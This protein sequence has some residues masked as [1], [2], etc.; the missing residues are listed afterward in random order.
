[1]LFISLTRQTIKH[2]RSYNL[3]HYCPVKLQCI[4]IL[5][6]WQ[7]TLI[8]QADGLGAEN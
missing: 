6:Q 2:R 3:I 8:R 5:S 4:N 7:E 1:M